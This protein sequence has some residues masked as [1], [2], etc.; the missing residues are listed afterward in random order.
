MPPRFEFSCTDGTQFRCNLH[1][2]RCHGRKA[3]GRRCTRHTYRPLT[4]CWQHTRSEQK[5]N[6]SRTATRNGVS[7]GRGLFAWHPLRAGRLPRQQGESKTAYDNRRR[8]FRGDYRRRTGP[9][10]I[11]DTIARYDGENVSLPVLENRYGDHTAPYGMTVFTGNYMDGAC[12][13]TVGS[14]VNHSSVRRETNSRFSRGYSG[15]RNHVAIIATKN[16]YHNDEII[17]N[18][19]QGLRRNDAT[20][21]VI[22][23]RGCGH[24]T[25]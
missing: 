7:I 22:N 16:I 4:R 3:N 14:Y 9:D 24:R 8:V 2:G 5:L 19:N 10:R 25:R 18:Y 13:R 15:G 21:Y 11:G 6:T 12:R 17:V 1:R 23:E 20:Y